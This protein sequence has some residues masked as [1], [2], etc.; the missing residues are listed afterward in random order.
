M[1]IKAKDLQVG[2]RVVVITFGERKVH[3]LTK[4]KV[5]P[6]LNARSAGFVG[7]GTEE[8]DNG[9]PDLNGTLD[10]DEEVEIE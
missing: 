8:W 6:A 1:I 2:M 10:L 5:H 9:I 7:V 4:V 3:T